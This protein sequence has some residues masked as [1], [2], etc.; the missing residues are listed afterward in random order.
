MSP[1]DPRFTLAAAHG[2]T[3]KVRD[4]WSDLVLR[5]PRLLVPIQLDVLAVRDEQRPWAD[6]AMRVPD[7][8]M[9]TPIDA[10]QLL[11][12][13][14]R[15]RAESRPRG[16][17]LQWALPDALAHGR[18]TRGSDDTTFPAVP[19]RWLVLRVSPSTRIVN[20]RT[21]R[22][23]VLRAGDRNPQPVN[24]DVWRETGPESDAA[25]EP[26]TALGYGDAGW[27]AYFDNVVN[28]LAFYDPLTDVANGPIAYLVCGWYSRPE[29]DPL[30]T[31]R[32]G[33]L[34]AFRARMSELRWSVPESQMT[35]AAARMRN[36]SVLA[37]RIGLSARAV[38]AARP[39]SNSVRDAILGDR[40]VVQDEWWPNQILCH[41]AVVGIGWPGVGWRG[42]E[43]G[44]LPRETGGP[45]NESAITVAIGNT[46][47][48]VMAALIVRAGKPDAEG[49]VLEAFQL[50]LLDE[51][52]EPDGR[53]RID[54]ALHASGFGSMP[55]GDVDDRV[56]EPPIEGPA[57]G[58]RPDPKPPTGIF[59]RNFRD[60][61][62]ATM[63]TGGAAAAARE[64]QIQSQID[65]SARSYLEAKVARGA[66]L[67]I[68]ERVFDEPPPQPRPGRWVDVK[69]PLPRYYHPTDAVI[70]V[71]NAK[72]SYR[73]GGDGRFDPNGLLHCR[74]TDST[75]KEVAIVNGE[76]RLASGGV[77][78]EYALDRA[79]DNGSVPPECEDLLREIVV[80][81]PGSAEALVR[82]GRNP[83]TP[84]PVEA[85]V[86]ADVRK[87]MVEQTVW[88]AL[89]DPH[90]D[91]AP[92]VARSGL[93]GVMP[94]PLALTPP[95][96]PWCPLHLDWKV[97][98]I[99][100]FV[101]E[102][103]WALE[104]IDYGEVADRVPP[105]G[106]EPP[107]LEIQGRTGLTGN[108][109]GILA[110]AVR[111]AIED[112][113]RA[114][115]GGKAPLKKAIVKHPSRTAQAVMERYARIR[116][117]AVHDSGS[118]GDLLDIAE[119][120]EHMDVI[121]G[122]LEDLH[123]QLRGGIDGDGRTTSDA[124][125]PNFVNLRAGYMRI[126]R[127]RL[128]DGFGQFV[129]LLGSSET[130][131][132]D[133][134]RVVTAPAIAVSGRKDLQA[135]PPRF[136]APARLWL[137]Y[138]KGQPESPTDLTEARLASDRAPAVSPVCGYLM[139]NH[140]DSALEFFGEDGS[141][142]GMIR[143]DL[144][145][146]MVWEDAP[147]TPITVGQS[148][149]RAMANPFLARMAQTML[150][151]GTADLQVA[152]P[153]ESVLSALMR[154]IDTTLWTIDP[155]AHQGDEHLS[156]LVGH[157]LVVL[158]GHLRL[159]VLEPVTSDAVR[160][161]A[162]PVR[163]GALTH[164]QDGLL[165]YFVNDD[166][167]T[168]YIPDP[169]SADQAREVGAM[170][171]FLGPIGDTQDYFARF[172]TEAQPVTHPYVNRS[173]WF[174][175]HPGQD[176]F[177]TLIV[178]PHSRVYA[179]SGLVPRKDIGMQREWVQ[180]A[181]GKLAPTFRFGPVLIDPER[182]RMPVATELNGTWSWDHRTDVN[183]WASNPVTHATHE[184]L[185]PPD[186]PEGSEGWLRLTPKP[187][188]NTR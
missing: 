185:L 114:G 154:V 170:N 161:M 165:G 184:A 151:W 6:C 141:N 133:A 89:R 64:A 28:R 124:V 112:A 128:V 158:R 25:P 39:G 61:V 34:G 42:H 116:T 37:S 79:V 140:L 65:K 157:P 173:G 58:T 93:A 150:D 164:W 77:R 101:R 148:P 17:Y 113:A 18:Q 9:P 100:T 183:R 19:D 174:N 40:L 97:R 13:P 83:R 11:P 134:A 180:Q 20:R 137:R 49:R 99:P 169:A 2:I 30:S 155:F 187:P 66:L 175:V 142:R 14:F 109:G 125:P 110:S 75:L 171:G 51:L 16:A 46:L 132:A 8:S 119:T 48:E 60:R 74:L 156:L 88:W 120:L 33:S 56:W 179:T 131:E 69:R 121:H 38:S 7:D 182:V 1:L 152:T 127:L 98:Y 146:R 71:Q 186:P 29:L 102:T 188:E 43:N 73:H 53:T 22:G 84:E 117:A 177:L 59:D 24:L 145:G 130:T 35:R 168:L 167:R 21:V 160:R 31:S 55:G 162:V 32:V 96:R 143:P 62:T 94:S 90:V 107:G 138:I 166:Y 70:A 23:W 159:E 122:V 95:Y 45:P 104:E 118:R 41:G 149:A 172:A 52:N 82:A 15:N 47:P 78:A 76:V 68:N 50:G 129:D 5:V 27:S 135:L 80:L 136:T 181:L 153:R 103:D 147:G 54:A 163:L 108:A 57:G 4:S 86:R 123:F 87:M 44:L 92:I 91:P 139:P 67:A 105:S 26:L 3:G 115:G 176:V 85:A 178:E 63:R 144:D 36:D 72:R 111:R 106:Q 12:P 81:D 126:L 10:R